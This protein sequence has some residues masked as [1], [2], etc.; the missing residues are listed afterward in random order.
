MQFYD[1]LV[2]EFSQNGDFLN[3][4]LNVSPALP[5]LTLLYCF[6]S[7]FGTVWVALFGNQVNFGEVSPSKKVTDGKVFFEIHKDYDIPHGFKP[8]LDNFLV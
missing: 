6:Q 1:A 3:H 8:L 5:D 2:L 7:E 4:R